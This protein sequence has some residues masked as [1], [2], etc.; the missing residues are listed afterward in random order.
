MY[1]QFPALTPTLGMYGRAQDALVTRSLEQYRMAAKIFEVMVACHKEQAASELPLEG[2]SGK[3]NSAKN[4][5][6]TKTGKGKGK[7]KGEDVADASKPS[8][9]GASAAGGSAEELQDALDAIRETIETMV[10]GKDM[11]ALEE[12][13]S[14]AA[15][16]T[17]GFGDSSSSSG[18]GAASGGDAGGST[19]VGFGG[20]GE[21]S[22]GGSNGVFSGFS[23]TGTAT[24]NIMVARRK[25]RPVPKIVENGSNGA[26]REGASK[27][28]KVDE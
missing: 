9:S 21:T 19:T 17:I 4:V 26:D 13:K 22:K 24:A 27:K 12:Y 23:S 25:G 5:T 3:E 14:G 10:S 28:P 15:S 16:T 8:T 20:T 7:S 18:A 6:D 2:S 1:M 11:E